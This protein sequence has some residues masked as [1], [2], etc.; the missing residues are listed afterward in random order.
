MSNDSD[1]ETCSKSP[2]ANSRSVKFKNSLLQNGIDVASSSSDV[3]K[4]VSQL[5]TEL[6]AANRTIKELRHREQQL[7]ERL[8]TNGWHLYC[9]AYVC[10]FSAKM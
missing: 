3:H 10:A 1:T 6:E 4:Q 7:L 2:A 9:I 5:K 8:V